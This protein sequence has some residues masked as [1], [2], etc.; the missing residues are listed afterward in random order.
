MT[1]LFTFRNNL[2]VFYVTGNTRVITQNA[3]QTFQTELGQVM[4]DP[5][6]VVMRQTKLPITLLQETAKV[7]SAIYLQGY[8]F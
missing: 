5:Y 2:D 3:L 6:R 7:N 4:K 8:Y 1:N